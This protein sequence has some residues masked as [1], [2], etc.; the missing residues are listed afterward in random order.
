ME[1][2]D[3][4]SGAGQ[5]SFRNTYYSVLCMTRTAPKQQQ[6]NLRTLVAAPW[7][8]LD[9]MFRVAV[10]RFLRGEHNPVNIPLPATLQGALPCFR[11]QLSRKMYVITPGPTSLNFQELNLYKSRQNPTG[12]CTSWH[13]EAWVYSKLGRETFIFGFLLT[14]NT[15][16][17]IKSN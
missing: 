3:K 17:T 15:S 6:S 10:T 12:I 9:L 4:I 2:G 5:D 1:V 13:P 16:Y 7:N 8:W 11:A 14:E